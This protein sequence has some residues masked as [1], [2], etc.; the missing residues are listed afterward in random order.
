MIGRG[1]GNTGVISGTGDKGVT[2]N[3]L[4]ATGGDTGFGAVFRSE[5]MCER[6]RS[7]VRDKK[8]LI[9]F[10][11]VAVWKFSTSLCNAYKLALKISK[12]GASEGFWRA[13]MRSKAALVAASRLKN[14]YSIPK[15]NTVRKG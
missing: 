8:G 7:S 10:F 12:G 6:G 5:M 4:G 15:R 2:F 1:V 11:G 13:V 14:R 3:T 9:E